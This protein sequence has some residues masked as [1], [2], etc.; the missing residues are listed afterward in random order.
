MKRSMTLPMLQIFD[1]PD[2]ATS[3]PRREASTVAPQALAL[4]N[5]DFT[6]R[7]AELFAARIR[8]QAGDNPEAEIDAGWRLAFGRTPSVGE[9]KIALDFLGRN[10]LP[11]LCLLMFNMSELIYVD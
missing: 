5:S 1:A 8:K 10:S 4:L 7:Q 3:C 2:T 9:R 6:Q 11:R